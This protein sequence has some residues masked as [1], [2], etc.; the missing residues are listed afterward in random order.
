VFVSEVVDLTD[1]DFGDAMGGD[2]TSLANLDREP[3]RRQLLDAAKNPA[4]AA[5]QGTRDDP[6]QL[7]GRPEPR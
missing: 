5:V 6:P 1:V 7:R 2:V 3:C 4:L